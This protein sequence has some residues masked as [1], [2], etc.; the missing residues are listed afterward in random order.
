MNSTTAVAVL[1]T[2]N[3]TFTVTPSSNYSTALVKSANSSNSSSI[4]VEKAQ[5]HNYSFEDACIPLAVHQ[6]P[7]DAVGD[8]NRE[9]GGVLVHLLTAFYIFGSLAYLCDIYF[10]PALEVLAERLHLK[11]DVAGATFMAIGSSSPELFTSLVGVYVAEDDVGVGT[12]IG[13]AVFNILFAI[14]CC[15]LVSPIA[16]QVE[17]FPIV[18]DSAFYTLAL[19]PLAAICM[20]REA[21]WYDAFGLVALYGVYLFMMYH[22][23]KLEKVFYRIFPG[24]VSGARETT[25]ILEKGEN[26]EMNSKKEQLSNGTT[27]GKLDVDAKYIPSGDQVEVKIVDPRED[28]DEEDVWYSDLLPP[29]GKLKRFLWFVGLPMITLMW[30]TIPNAAKRRWKRWFPM[31]FLVSLVYIGTLSYLMVWMVTIIGYT[32]GIPD[33]IMGLIFIAAG[34]SVPDCL[35][36]I[37]VARHGMGHMSVSNCIGSNVFDVLLGLGLPWLFKTLI[38]DYGESVPIISGSIKFT[39]F[40]LIA[41]VVAMLFVFWISR[42]K[43]RWPSGLMLITLYLGFMTISCLF[44]L[45]VFG[46]YNLPHCE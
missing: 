22:S 38:T 10:V 41:S 8:E 25:P 17:I 19:I 14:G 13:S 26:N 36:S 31:T 5:R 27:N 43:L 3:Q 28:Q 15:I 9:R 40:I 16:I 2:L 39:V 4:V 30:L 35:A 46:K 34:A 11:P 32:I 6:F 29:D 42:W 1:L 23:E 21:S 7:R 33:I 12:I 44:E 18:R 37:I 20:D 24:A 45:N